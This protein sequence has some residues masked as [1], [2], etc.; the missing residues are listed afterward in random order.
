MPEK[1][2]I[3]FAYDPFTGFWGKNGLIQKKHQKSFKICKETR[4]P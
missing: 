3:M 2:Q 4:G 1:A